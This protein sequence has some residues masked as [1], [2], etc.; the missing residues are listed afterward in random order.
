MY[1]SDSKQ[2]PLEQSQCTDNSSKVSVIPRLDWL[3]PLFKS[4]QELEF[5]QALKD[6]Y[7]NY[8]IY[9]NVAL[10]N[11]FNFD[12]MSEAISSKHQYYFFKAVIDFVVYDPS[13]FHVPKYFFEVDSHYHD[14]PKAKIK[15]QMKN[16][17]FYRLTS[18][19]TE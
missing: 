6:L 9:P 2:Q 10:S 11:I 5:Y 19:Y 13:D 8:F 4:S 16:D 1:K 12:G 18:P 3:A 17:I 15:D 14:N 7:P